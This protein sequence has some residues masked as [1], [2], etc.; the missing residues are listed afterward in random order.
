M[1]EEAIYAHIIADSTLATKVANGVGKY[2][3]YPLRAP[4]GA[5]PNKMLVY[6]EISQSLTYPLVR[7][8]RFQISCIAQTFEDARGMASDIDRIFNDYSEGKLGGT[9]G[10]KY[11]KY[12][13]RTALF[14]EEAKLYV[15]PVEL[16]I[17]F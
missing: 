13:G 8:S 6:R 7:S 15:F 2:H 12:E 10:V 16:F 11:I 9:F 5:A 3:I 4:D 1:L 17:K 14:D